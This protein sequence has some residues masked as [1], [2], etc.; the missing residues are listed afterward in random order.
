[1]AQQGGEEPAVIGYPLQEINQRFEEVGERIDEV[2]SGL[3]QV[4]ATAHDVQIGLTTIIHEQQSEHARNSER[5]EGMM[6]RWRM[7]QD[8]SRRR[9]ADNIDEL[10]LAQTTREKHVAD[11]GTAVDTFQAVFGEVAIMT[12]WTK[13]TV[14][15]IVNLGCGSVS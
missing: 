6:S 11:I 1:M 13:Q 5:H 14:M 8:V 12:R 7:E 4:H 10:K 2:V 15:R 3:G 9:H